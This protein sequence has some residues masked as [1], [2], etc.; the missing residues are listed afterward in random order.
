MQEMYEVVA[1][2]QEYREFVPCVRSLGSIQ[3]QRSLEG[4]VGGWLSTCCGTLHFCQFHCQT[5]YGQ[6]E[7]W[8]GVTDQEVLLCS[9]A[10]LHLRAILAFLMIFL[11]PC[12]RY[13][14]NI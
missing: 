7:A 6:G 2:V 4:P 11:S 12:V 5:S 3:P 13:F 9:V 1:N 14:L 8:L 10:F